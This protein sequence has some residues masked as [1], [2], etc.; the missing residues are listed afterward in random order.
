VDTDCIGQL[1]GF[2]DGIETGEKSPPR[3]GVDLEKG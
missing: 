2:A 3:V 1:E